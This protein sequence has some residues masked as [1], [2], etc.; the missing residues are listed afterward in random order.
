MKKIFIYIIIIATFL[1]CNRAPKPTTTFYYWRTTWQ[2]TAEEQQ[3]LQA[4]TAGKL[5]VRLF[6]VA[7]NPLNQGRPGP[8]AQ[9]DT[10]K[11]SDLAQNTSIIPVI[12]IV[13]K[14]LAG[15]SKENA[16]LLGQQIAKLAAHKLER[17]GQPT[18]AL[19][20]DCDWS[21]STRDAFFALVKGCQTALPK[22]ELSS[23]IRLHQVRDYKKTGIPPVKRG[24]VM[25]Y[26]MGDV[27][28]AAETNSIL[29]P[30][31]AKMYLS[32]LANYPLPVDIALPLFGWGVEERFGKPIR[33]LDLVQAED[34]KDTAHFQAISPNR[35]RVVASHYQHG[36]YLYRDA[37]IRYEHA[38]P[39]SLQALADI[40][41]PQL[42]QMDG[43]REVVYYH[44]QPDLSAVYGADF[45]QK[46]AK[47]LTE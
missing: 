27:G 8:I 20:L 16:N 15:L 47:Q 13:N 21:N 40:L 10:L 3:Y 30:S 6:D 26:N 11:T 14:T 23:T 37:V 41:R 33:I 28:S 9:L 7:P 43:P 38:Y 17:W 25:C 31:V 32:D 46:L 22:A 1:S 24:M 42:Q 5:Y 35:Y 36:T 12:F 44:L 18:T 29:R 34:L 4:A 45:V 19:Q 39:D 2:L